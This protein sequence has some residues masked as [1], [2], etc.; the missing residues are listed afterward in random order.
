M[1]KR[2]LLYIGNKLSKKGTTVSTIDTLGSLLEREG[3]N[4]YSASSFK[5]KLIRILDMTFKTLR[6]SSRVSVVL[7][8]TYSTNNFYYALTIAKLCR[9]LRIPYI[10]ILHGGNLPERL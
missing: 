3:L 9:M 5:N 8:D 10:P 1:Q 2:S 7:I 4:V 6:Y